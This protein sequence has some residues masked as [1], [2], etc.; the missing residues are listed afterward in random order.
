[1]VSE[2]K[3]IGP[4]ETLPD[5]EE[6][7]PDVQSPDIQEPSISDDEAISDYFNYLT[8]LTATPDQM[9]MLRAIIHYD[10]VEAS[11]GRQS[12]KT[13]TVSVATMYLAY[14]Y[15]DPLRILLISPQDNQVYGYMRGFFRGEHH[16][17]LV[18]DL[19]GSKSV[20]NI[21]PLTGFSLGRGTQVKVCGVTERDIRGFPA[22]VVIVDEAALVSNQSILTAMGN[23]SGEASKLILLSTPIYNPLINTPNEPKFMK[24][25]RDPEYKVF[26][27]SSADLPWHN[28]RLLDIKRKEFTPAHWASEVLGREP[29]EDEI[30]NSGDIIGEV[31]FTTVPVERR[32]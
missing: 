18:E 13:L 27:W 24:W 8:G 26:H 14:K 3:I 16:D 2:A 17:E 23:L 1:M 20:Q 4:W 11:A 9:E 10:R 6:S 15:H 21:V 29:T 19:I 7:P 5:E 28:K 31:I 25:L 32:R 30:S 12:G 22:D